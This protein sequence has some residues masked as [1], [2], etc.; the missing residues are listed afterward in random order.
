MR[1]TLA[2]SKLHIALIGLLS[3]VGCKTLAEQSLVDAVIEQHST[4]SID[5]LHSIVAKALN[6]EKITLAPDALTQSS[7]LMIE[8][9]THRTLQQGVLMGRSEEMPEIFKLKL[10]GKECL[11]LHPISNRSWPLL[12]SRCKAG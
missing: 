1:T 5:E 7:R 12:K 2:F 10:K 9:K 3:L 6:V 8:R 4:E 11:L